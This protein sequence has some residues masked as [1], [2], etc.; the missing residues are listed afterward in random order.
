MYIHLQVWV[1]DYALKKDLNFFSWMVHQYHEDCSIDSATIVLMSKFM[2]RNISIVNCDDM[3]NIED[4]ATDI[5]LAHIS[6]SKFIATEV[7]TYLSS[8][9]LGLT[10]V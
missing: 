9:P 7:G 1:E 6:G 3:L 8:N 10:A 2:M 4:T 5:V